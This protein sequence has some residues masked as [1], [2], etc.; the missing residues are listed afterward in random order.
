MQV[1]GA[2]VVIAVCFVR[3]CLTSTLYASIH[4][5]ILT[6]YQTHNHTLFIFSAPPIGERRF[7][8][9]EPPTPWAPARL[10]ATQYGPD[11]WQVV[12]PVLNPNVHRMSE[13]CLSVNVFRPAGVS[14][15][16]GLPVLV[17][18]HGGAF[19]QGGAHR[20]EYNGQQLAGRGV[21]VVTLNYRLG[22]LGFLVSRS[23]GITGNFGLMDQRAAL[24][25]VRDNI[26]VFGGVSTACFIAFQTSTAPLYA[27]TKKSS[28]AV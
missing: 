5:Y 21:V 7:A 14:S 10:D 16:S 23:D 28:P 2:V 24:Y 26:S 1:R 13:D 4:T 17:W 20:P 27:N 15:K 11:C 12:D 19:Q 8:G 18:L 6:R 22:A 3:Q 25:W 9:P